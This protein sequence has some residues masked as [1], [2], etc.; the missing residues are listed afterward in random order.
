MRVLVERGSAAG[1]LWAVGQRVSLDESEVHHLRVRRAKDREIV[2]IL[3]G[4]GLR[5]T[6]RLLQAGKQ[7]AVE[8]Q[9]AHHE[10]RPPELTLAVA[11]G[12]RDRFSWMVEKA[13]ELGV[14]RIV[15]LE[16]ARSSGVATGIRDAHLRR[17]RRHALEATKQCGV[18]WAVHVEEPLSLDAFRGRPLAG[19]GWLAD[20]SGASPPTHLGGNILTVVIGPEGGLG[21]A[22]RT[23][24]IAA[25]YVPI[26]LGPHAL[27]FETAALAAAALATTARMRGSHG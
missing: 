18:A 25:G 11:S 14:T 16:T 2:E 7:W 3:D 27:R 10:P 21:D 13:V 8:V 26:V 6:G 17:L 9:S 5:G 24:L 12:D 23:G 20:R 15:P 19:S 22:E 1:A 4:A